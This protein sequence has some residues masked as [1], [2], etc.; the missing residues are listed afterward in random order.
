MPSLAHQVKTAIGE[1]GDGFSLYAG[2]GVQNGKTIRF[3]NGIQ[4][5]GRRSPTGR[6]TRAVYEYA[7]GSRLTYA[8]R[9]STGYTLTVE[10]KTK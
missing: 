8:Y 3:P 10:E 1:C 9:E 5:S 7:D 2:Y 4:L 6:L